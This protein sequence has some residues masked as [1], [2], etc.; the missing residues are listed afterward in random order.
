M[1]GGAGSFALPPYD[2]EDIRSDDELGPDGGS[3]VGVQDLRRALDPNAA[4][5]LFSA[6]GLS[7]ADI[8]L[9]VGATERSVRRW[10]A[11][12][13]ATSPTRYRKQI[14]DLRAILVVLDET[15]TLSIDGAVHWLRARNRDLGDNRPLDVLRV[16]DFEAVR[17]AALV[18]GD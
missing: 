13:Q 17:A 5:A 16:G 9:A 10:R 6:V 4:V 8:A 1:T 14:D 15:G 18:F 3:R 2:E 11:G 7:D 12:D